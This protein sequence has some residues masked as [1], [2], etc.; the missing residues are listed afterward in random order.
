MMPHFK[1][2]VIYRIISIH[3]TQIPEL[4]RL[5]SVRLLVDLLLPFFPNGT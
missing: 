2:M 1:G 3:K 4:I 5:G